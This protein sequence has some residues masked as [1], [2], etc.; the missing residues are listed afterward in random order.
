MGIEIHELNIGN[1]MLVFDKADL[2]I[3]PDESIL[4]DLEMEPFTA[5]PGILLLLCAMN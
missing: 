3:I 1:G 2:E 4:M 5:I